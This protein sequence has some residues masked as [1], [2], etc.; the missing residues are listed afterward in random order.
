M[1]SRE[2][3]IIVFCGVCFVC[4]SWL[5]WFGL[6]RFGVLETDLMIALTGLEL[7]V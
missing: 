6:V 2:R 1:S 3:N 4:L 7:A 5:L